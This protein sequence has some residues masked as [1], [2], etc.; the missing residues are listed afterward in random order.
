MRKPEKFLV[1]VSYP[2]IVKHQTW[3]GMNNSRKV[4]DWERAVLSDIEDATDAN[5]DA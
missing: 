5:L 1:I 2:P 3:S 4:D